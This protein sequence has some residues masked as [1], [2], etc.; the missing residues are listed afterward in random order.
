[1]KKA[2]VIFSGGLDS[3][4]TAAYLK[5]NYELYGISYLYGQRAS[6]EIQ[7]AKRFAKKLLKQHR[8]V[9]INFMKE[10]Y[11]KSNVLTDSKRKLPKDFEYSIV[12]PIRNAIFLSIATAWA[13]TMN[14]SLVA[15]GAHTG[16]K[17]YPDCR[18]KFAK[19]LEYALNEG[20]ADGIKNSLRKPIEIWSPYRNRFSKSTLLKLGYQ[21]LGKSIFDTWSCYESRKNHC[22]KCE[23]CM[24]RKRAFE[25]A[26]IADLTRYHD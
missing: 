24:N 8:I 4:C 15:Y 18:P 13:F 6:K 1:M 19:K 17:F 5:S 9:D 26:R 21:K 14:A 10:L 11:G 20:E 23:S 16:D 12:V 7:V 22:G 25:S 2:V 3:M